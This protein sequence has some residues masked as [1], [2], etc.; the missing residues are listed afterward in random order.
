MR[1]AGTAGWLLHDVKNRGITAWLVAGAL[2]AFYLVL[3][4]SE[5]FTPIAE[6]LHLPHKWALYGLLYTIAVGGGGAYVMY[7]YRHNAYQIVR[8]SV[9]IAVQVIIAFSIP[10]IL[11]IMEKFKNDQ[12][13]C[14]ALH[15]DGYGKHHG[16]AAKKTICKHNIRKGFHTYALVWTPKEYVFYIDGKESWRTS[17]GGVS[18][19]PAFVKLT[20]EVSAKGKKKWNGDPAKANLPDHFIVDYVRV[21]DTVPGLGE[22]AK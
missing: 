14:Q 18:Q 20:T 5:V 1:K 9:V 15:W 4:Y 2:L 10:V 8:T 7:K 19:V 3:Y 16:N 22:K 12:E 6:A 11:D 13:I 21:Y 17:A